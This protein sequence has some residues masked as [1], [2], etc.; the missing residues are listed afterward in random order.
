L[1]K[2]VVDV[3]A[4]RVQSARVETSGAKPYTA[5]KRSRTDADFAVEGLP[6]GKQLSDA[7]AANTLA[8]ALASLTLS[9]V[10]AADA[11]KDAATDKA[12]YQTFDGLIVEVQGWA[13]DDKHYVAIQSR[14]D[15]ALAD[16]F[17]APSEP[18]AEE[19]DPNAKDADAKNADAKDAAAK[20]ATASA[21]IAQ[22]AKKLNDRANGWVFEIPEHKYGSIFKPIGDLLAD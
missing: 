4:D 3:S 20:P 18:G 1:S 16:Q 14:Y 2:T 19:P 11:L 7:G 22:Q 21:D 15:Q 10:Q 5:T 9:D 17:K 8:T 13:R 12:V 6:K